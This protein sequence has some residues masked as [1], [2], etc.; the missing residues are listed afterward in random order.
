VYTVQDNRSKSS[1][2]AFKRSSRI[3]IPITF[4]SK[5]GALLRVMTD[6]EG[7]LSK[8]RTFAYRGSSHRRESAA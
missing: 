3:Q 7:P 6:I 4:E 1:V 5:T 2:Q 8:F